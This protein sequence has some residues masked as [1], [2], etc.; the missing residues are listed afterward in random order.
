MRISALA[1]ATLA[2]FGITQASAMDCVPMDQI[3]DLTIPL[4]PTPAPPPTDYPVFNPITFAS[5]VKMKLWTW[6][7]SYAQSSEPTMDNPTIADVSQCGGSASQKALHTNASS[8]Y[9]QILGGVGKVTFKICD[10]TGPGNLSGDAAAPQSFADLATV[11]A[12]PLEGPF[13]EPITATSVATSSGSGYE[14][15][16][17]GGPITTFIVGAKAVNIAE[18]CVE[19]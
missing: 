7:F 18:V 1:L 12:E 8:L 9:G 5:G 13:K 15:T 14:L 2:A 6:N 4:N 16:L 19:P 3:L 17:S 10:F 11:S